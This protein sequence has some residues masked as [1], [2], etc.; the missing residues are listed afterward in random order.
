MQESTDNPPA[1]GATAAHDK[2]GKIR[3]LENGLLDVRAE[4]N[5]A[6]I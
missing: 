6:E 3:R 2:T 4:G 5:Y 1:T